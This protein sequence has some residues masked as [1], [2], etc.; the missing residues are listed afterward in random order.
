MAR[1]RGQEMSLAFGSISSRAWTKMPM[2][3]SKQ[4]GQ[5][6][7][8]RGAGGRL[9]DPPIFNSRAGWTSP[10]F[11]LIHC[12]SSFA[13]PSLDTSP[14]MFTEVLDDKACSV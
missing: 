13:A 9:Q 12:S 7:I 5:Y 1:L 11:S 4:V 2:V 8:S 6:A 14:D 10:P 3:L